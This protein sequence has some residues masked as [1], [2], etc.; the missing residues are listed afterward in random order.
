MPP[1]KFKDM[2]RAYGFDEVAIVTGDVTINPDQVNTNFV[3]GNFTFTV[4]IL[5]SAMDAVVDPKMAIRFGKLGGLAV[6]NLDGIQ[7]RYENADDVLTEIA[8][9]SDKEVTAL[10][11]KIYRQPIKEEL[12]A[13]RVQTIKMGGAV[14]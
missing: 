2:E 9:A 8:S 14:C 5:A 12:V 13:E 3:I 6:L 4:P 10:L 11:Q 7:V 1:R